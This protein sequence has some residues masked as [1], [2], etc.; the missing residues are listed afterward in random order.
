LTCINTLFTQT[1]YSIAEER[2]AFMVDFFQRMAAE[3]SEK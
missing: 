3:V 1:A 2:H